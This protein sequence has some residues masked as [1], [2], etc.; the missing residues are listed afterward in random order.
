MSLD[1]RHRG[2]RGSRCGCEACVCV[3]LVV[4]MDRGRSVYFLGGI[5]GVVVAGGRRGSSTRSLNKKKGVWTCTGVFLYCIPLGG[6]FDCLFRLQ[7]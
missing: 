4:G 6:I 7:S 2:V 3:F 5:S 1:R